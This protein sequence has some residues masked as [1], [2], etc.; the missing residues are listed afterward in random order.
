MNWLILDQLISNFIHFLF[1]TSQNKTYDRGTI[2]KNGP[3]TFL[4][5]IKYV[6]NA[7][8]WIVLPKPISSAKIPFKLL[9]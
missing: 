2:I 6:I 8:V 7:I 3:L 5:S 4:R 1:K 9:L